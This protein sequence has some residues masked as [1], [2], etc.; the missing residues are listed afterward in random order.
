M[1]ISSDRLS[2][3]IG[4]F[5][6]ETGLAMDESKAY[7]IRARLKPLVRKYGYDSLELMIDEIRKNKRGELAAEALDQMTTNETL[8]FRDAYPFEVL[9]KH[10]FPQLLENQRS[11]GKIKIWSAAASTGQ[12][13]YSIAMTA[14]E[15]ITQASSSVKVIGTDISK[16]SI[17]YAKEAI[18]KQMEV[19]RG[20]PAQ[21]LKQFFLQQDDNAWK[22][23]DAL[24]SM[25]HFQEA[26]LI[27]PTLVT[28]L[29][30]YAPFNI[31]FCRN[32]LIYFDVEQR[33]LVIDQIAQLTEIG[34]YLFT[35]A[36][37]L[38]EGKRSK[39][40]AVRFENRPVWRLL[41]KH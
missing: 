36:G 34:G 16:A 37:E 33:K 30:H 1:T 24:R 14:S 12:E 39:W 13:A 23:C 20:M 2:Y 40:E 28:T 26:N 4:F 15:E 25:V 18:Y 41:A 17:M 10:L 21:K 27:A 31:V 19:Q 11:F 38:V 35:G 6:K 3:L 7:L 8:F 32:V 22:V 9:K 29:R 5:K